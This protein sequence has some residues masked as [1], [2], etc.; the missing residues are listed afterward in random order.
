MQ[1]AT[2]HHLHHA[3]FIVMEGLAFLQ[4]PLCALIRVICRLADKNAALRIQYQS[5]SSQKNFTFLYV[6]T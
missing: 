6:Y 4:P 1:F 3:L 2:D 5:S